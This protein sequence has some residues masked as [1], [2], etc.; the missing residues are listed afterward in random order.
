MFEEKENVRF[1][2]LHFDIAV[3]DIDGF[4]IRF[5]IVEQRDIDTQ[6]FFAFALLR[7]D[8]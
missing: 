4:L 3:E 1:G 8:L 7:D 2:K 5:G 6:Q